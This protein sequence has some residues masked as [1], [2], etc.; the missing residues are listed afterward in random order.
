MSAIDRN[1][2]NGVRL[3]SSLA[4]CAASPVPRNVH[5]SW[6]AVASLA[7]A[8]LML[9][10][11]PMAQAQSSPVPTTPTQTL[12]PVKVLVPP[13][14][15][16]CVDWAEHLRQH[17]FVVTLQEVTDIDAEKRRLKIPDDM[18]SRHTA[19]VAGYFVEGHVPASDILSLLKEKPAALGIAV[20][21]LPRGAPGR[22]VSQPF[23]E[24]GCTILDSNPA[25][26]EIKREM[27]NTYLILPDGSTK[28]WER[29]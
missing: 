27:F 11:A 5:K 1:A 16:A 7:A 4:P 24:T 21:G 28:I 22:E 18:S 20:P 29:H 6:A 13:V 2:F 23:C 19:L 8:L 10:A 12:P 25:D 9:T 17:G 3:C 14:C 15:L 26:R